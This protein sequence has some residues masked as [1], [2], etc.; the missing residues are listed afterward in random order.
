MQF[1]LYVNIRVYIV[2][3]NK[4][5]ESQGTISTLICYKLTYL[6][7]DNQGPILDSEIDYPENQFFR[8]FFL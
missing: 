1:S 2:K 3:L 7:L 6:Q 8:E 5:V 4:I